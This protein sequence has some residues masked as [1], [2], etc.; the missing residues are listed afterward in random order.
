MPEDFDAENY[1]ADSPAFY[2][3]QRDLEESQPRSLLHYKPREVR[4]MVASGSVSVD[5]G[6][7]YVAYRDLQKNGIRG[8]TA[9]NVNRLYKAGVLTQDQAE[10]Y[11]SY[12]KHPLWFSIC[13]MVVV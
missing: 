8:M 2:Q 11:V 6:A 13:R 5:A 12:K 1:S 7:Q 4:D 9:R 3:E 10:S